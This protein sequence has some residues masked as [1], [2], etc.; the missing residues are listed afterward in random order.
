MSKQCFIDMGNSRIKWWLCEN[1]HIIA[2]HACWHQQNLAA[3]A[4]ELPDIF[5]QPV[6]FVGVSSVL[7]NQSNQYL[8]WLSESWWHKKPLFAQ[9]SSQH[10]GIQCGY[11]QPE[12]LGIDRWLNILAVA[13]QQPVCVVSC[14]TAL[15]VDFV[16][17]HQHLGGFI[18]PN[19]NLQ[20]SALI[21]GTQGVRPSV[22][23]HPNLSLGKNTSEAVYHGILLACVGAIET[24]YNQ[25]Q[26]QVAKPLKLVLTG[27]NAAKI[28]Q[29]L[30]IA[31]DII[32][33]LL[34]VGMQRY[35]GCHS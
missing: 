16:H 10:L 25:Q 32:P 17:E 15:T 27:G 13:P 4:A 1:Q 19:M 21:Q 23:E 3:F 22:I 31:H 8:T 9:T 5:H 33:E 12:R 14:G 30:H 24:A 18:L 35:F 6:D 28:G 2:S 11:H 20:L 26:K 34:L 29:H 7:D